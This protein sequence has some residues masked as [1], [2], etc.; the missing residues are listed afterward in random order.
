MNSLC[1][2]CFVLFCS[3]FVF[4]FVASSLATF[5]RFFLM[6]LE[7]LEPGV[8]DAL[9]VVFQSCPEEEEGGRTSESDE[10]RRKAE[11]R[12]AKIQQCQGV[13]AARAVVSRGG[14]TVMSLV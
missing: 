12:V 1:P 10:E 9:T 2:V 4:A 11:A 5:P 3:C 7:V 14:T 13:C 8:S 6:S